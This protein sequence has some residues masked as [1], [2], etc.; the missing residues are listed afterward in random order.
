MKRFINARIPVLL[1]LFTAAGIGIGYALVYHGKN[2]FPIIAVIPLT[3]VIFILF[4]LKS[5]RIT[6]SVTVVLCALLLILG[7][8]G[9]FTKLQNYDT[10]DLQD[11]GTYTVSATVCDRGENKVGEFLVI[12]NMRVGGDKISGKAYVYLHGS[13]GDL[14][15]IGYKVKF[16]S[17]VKVYDLFTYG[18]L[19]Y[20]AKENIKYS[21]NIY[22]GL[23]A[24]RGFSAFGSVRNAIYK[25]V[26][27]NLDPS[28]AG[29]A[30]AM[31]TGSTSGIDEGSL[32]SFRYGGIAHIFAVSGLHIGIIF[33]ILSFITKKARL[34]KY[35][36]AA[37]CLLCVFFYAGVC[38]FTPSSLRAAVMCTVLTI[39]KLVYRKYDGLNS[40]AT[41][42]T[43]ILLISPLNLFDIGFQLSVSAVLGIYMLSNKIAKLLKRLPRKLSTGIG[44]SLGAQAGTMPVMLTGFG[45]VS[46]AGLILNIAVIPTL[47]IIFEILFIATFISVIIP[48][49]A[50]AILPIAALPL[51]AV[52]SFVTDC[53]FEKALIRGFGAGAFVPLLFILIILLSDKLNMRTA[54]RIIAV[55]SAAAVIIVYVV[56]KAFAPFGGYKITVSGYYGGGQILVKS[57][58]GSVLIITE[59]LNTS[60][61]DKLLNENYV[62]DVD[63]LIILGGENCVTA[64]GQTGISCDSVIVYDKY[65]DVHPYEKAEVQYC[66]KF[67][68]F[69]AKYE[70]YDGYNLKINCCGVNVA[71][72]SGGQVPLDGYELLICSE[73][74]GAPENAKAVYWSGHGEGYNIYD[75]G[76]VTF[77]ADDGKLKQ[78]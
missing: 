64:Y 13:Y 63:A 25:A 36:S 27:N 41:A 53:G 35:A 31:L 52:I 65:I 3:A 24:K 39:S 5:R 20:N 33:A 11:G 26:Y 30:Y 58:G 56:L 28:T 19:N 21:F 37:I 44:A 71:I 2:L 76:D 8:V 10:S 74:F 1:A 67:E 45:Y 75:V 9:S 42:A 48:V 7:A 73:G 50:G 49:T 23:E 46:G 69:G 78:K 77:L 34:N 14:A 54:R 15:D 22:S 40:L 66:H 32:Q 62:F 51:E 72:C 60:Q 57:H 43:I 18:K 12:K 59:N 55:G 29:I 16:T 70:F 6:P 68:L 47:S 4:I 17:T 61:I 38:G